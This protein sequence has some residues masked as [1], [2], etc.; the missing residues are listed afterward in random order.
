MGMVEGT[1]MARL[2]VMLITMA[3]A[4]TWSEDEYSGTSLIRTAWDQRL[5]RLV[6]L[7]HFELGAISVLFTANQ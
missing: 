5:F 4:L 1:F 6:G 7:A 2:W 3:S